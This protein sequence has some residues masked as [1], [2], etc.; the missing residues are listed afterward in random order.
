MLRIVD[1]LK[2]F[3]CCDTP[4]PVLLSTVLSGMTLAVLGVELRR[5]TVVDAYALT[6][7]L[8]YVVKSN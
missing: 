5:E 3:I 8:F 2:D 6:T 7:V 4:L 1:H